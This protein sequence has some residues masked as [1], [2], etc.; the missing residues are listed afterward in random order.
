MKL[1]N[2]LFLFI[3]FAALGIYVYLVEFKQY[4]KKQEAAE[5][6]KKLFSMVKDSVESFTF[7]NFYGNFTLKRIQDQWKITEPLYTEAD[8]STV[9]SMVG[10]LVGAQIETEFE[11]NPTELVNFGLGQ[12]AVEVRLTDKNG[13]M[14]SIRLG[15]KTPVGTFVFANKVDTTI[16]TINQ[17]IKTAFEKKLFD[18]RYKNLMQF[19]RNDVRK[20]VLLNQHGKMEFE[21]SGSNDWTFLNID[22]LADNTKINSLL[23]KLNSNQAKEFVD[24]SGEELGKYGL[25]KSAFA[26]ELFLGPE[27][28]QK[29]LLLSGKLDGKYYAKDESRKP[30]FIV[31][32]T[33]F[34]DVN[35]TSQDFR[36]KDI[37]S[38]T[39]NDIS[40]V[41]I[42]YG[43]TSFTCVK[44]SG[45]NWFLDDSSLTSIQKQKMNTFF[46]NLD[47]SNATEFVKD[48]AYN[49]ANYGLDKPSVEVTL[50]DAGGKVLRLI[51]GNKKDI[52]IY[53][54]TDQ[55]ESV[56][57]IP[58][59]KLREFKLKLDDILEKPVTSV[60]ELP[61]SSE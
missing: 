14:D 49:P 45:D 9:N 61:E 52:N 54:A 35:Q 59:R 1:R 41:S 31:D 22:R 6:S 21:K 42:S 33:V 11:V 28:G 7:H 48:G 3:L 60:E 58:I 53:A 13:T 2:T 16:F 15:D 18:I 57:L 10:T 39:R 47:Y 17:G 46:S 44:D 8:E 27:Q 55:Y 40:R 56:Y 19:N 30:I 34:E 5:E 26:V 12:N 37:V 20:I 24:E 29:R 32:S 43:D 23:S 38:F 36:G 25:K 50:Y 4:E 51:L